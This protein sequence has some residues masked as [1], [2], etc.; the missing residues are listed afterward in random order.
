MKL[1]HKKILVWGLLLMLLFL[2]SIPGLRYFAGQP[3][4]AGEEPYYHLRM[5]ALIKESGIPETD[6][7][8]EREYLVQ[9]YHVLL[10]FTSNIEL[11]SVLIPLLAGL[12]SFI[13]FYFIL[14]NLNLG[15]HEIS[16]TLVAFILSPLSIF[17]FA[18]SN[19]HSLSVPLL[20]AGFL[21]FIKGRFLLSFL[22][23]I[24]TPFFWNLGP[25]NG[26]LCASCLFHKQQRK[27]ETFSFYHGF[28]VA[29]CF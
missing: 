11:F 2:I 17:L 25:C 7:F 12:L 22:F 26:N 29:Y 1:T 20:L 21:L 23:F 9:P 16:V 4:L 18:T 8:V 27:D 10:S 14:R 24:A 15:I 6:P 19:V 13:L 3:I 28:C 5:A